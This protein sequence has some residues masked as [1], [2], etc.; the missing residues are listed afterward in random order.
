MPVC[1]RCDK[2]TCKDSK[3]YCEEHLKINR[4]YYTKTISKRKQDGV[5]VYCASPLAATSGRLCERHL[6]EH[7]MYNKKY[8]TNP[9][10]Y[11][12]LRANAKRRGIDVI[13]NRQEFDNW[14]GTQS[15]TCYYCSV[16]LSIDGVNRKSATIDRKDNNEPYTLDNMCLSCFRCNNLKSDFFREDEW[17]EICKLFVKPRLDEYHVKIRGEDG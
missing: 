8:L 11:H 1:K 10:R 7:R 13:C 6:E 16:E 14:F 12:Q 3:W 15:K 9:S 5:C 2:P 17:L 4:G